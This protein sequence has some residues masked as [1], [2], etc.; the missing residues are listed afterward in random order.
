MRLKA[1]L[2]L[3][4]GLFAIPPPPPCAC[5]LPRRR[6]LQFPPAGSSQSEEDNSANAAAVVELRCAINAGLPCVVQ[7]MVRVRG[8][9]AAGAAAVLWGTAPAQGIDTEAQACVL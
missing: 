4:T 1:P 7:L 5:L 3:C 8:A 2:H 9:A 6:F